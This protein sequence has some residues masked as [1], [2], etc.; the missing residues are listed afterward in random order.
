[1]SK[2]TYIALQSALNWTI[3]V[4]AISA[5]C[6]YVS[7]AFLDAIEPRKSPCS[8]SDAPRSQ[9]PVPSLGFGELSPTVLT[10]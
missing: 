3:I 2:T 4:A 9:I 7:Q 5:S 1:M 6:G 10:L 8:P